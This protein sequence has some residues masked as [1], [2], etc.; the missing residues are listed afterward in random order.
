MW[1]LLF[2]LP[3]IPSLLYFWYR[4]NTPTTMP[5][6]PRIPQPPHQQLQSK[7][8]NLSPTA[9]YPPSKSNY[10]IEKIGGNNQIILDRKSVV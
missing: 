9:T 10:I 7:F 6:L 8:D 5:T 2:L 3:L 4:I 1:E